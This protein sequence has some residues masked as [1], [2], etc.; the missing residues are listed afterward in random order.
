MLT[1]LP[2]PRA[3]ALTTTALAAFGL[4][5]LQPFEIGGW[6]DQAPMSFDGDAEPQIALRE[7]SVST[8]AEALA[9]VIEEAPV[10]I[11]PEPAP[12][13]APAR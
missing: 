5:Y 6:R 12:Q 11:A 1:T 9:P 7:R 4:L 2:T 3:L 8:E 10:A 13:P